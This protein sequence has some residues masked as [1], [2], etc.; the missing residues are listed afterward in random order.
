MTKKKSILFSLQLITRFLLGLV[1][2][3][4]GTVKL[5][6]PLGTAYKIADYLTAFGLSQVAELGWLM[7]VCSVLLSAT[8]FFLGMILLL[9]IKPKFAIGAIA[10]FMLLFTPLTL[11]IAITNP[12][13]DC[14]CFGDA[15]L[16]SNWA[17]FVKNVVLLCMIATQWVGWRKMH[18]LFLPKVEWGIM[19]LTFLLAMGF[20]GYN[21]FYLPVMD[22]R[23]YPIGTDIKAAMT[24]PEGAAVDKYETTFVYAQNDVEKEFTLANYPKNDATWKFVRQNTQLIS[25]GY[26]PPISDLYLYNDEMEDITDLILESKNN[27]VLVIMYDLNSVKRLSAEKI[28][29]FYKR[30]LNA[31]AEFYAVT[32]SGDEDRNAFREKYLSEYDFYTADPIVLKTMIRANP[33]IMLLKDGIIID[34][35]NVNELYII[36]N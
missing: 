24:I 32:S 1:F 26:E 8:E 18:G 17:T 27:V 34:K 6:D 10:A 13:S 14:G 5:I 9:K 36:N 23:P 4:S 19:I 12:V 25:K 30:T 20:A 11:Y 22:F 31:G 33:G 2:V 3:F 21:L 7:V 15:V 16:L 29:S 35:W 28:N